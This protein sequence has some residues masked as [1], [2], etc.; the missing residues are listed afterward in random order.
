MSHGILCRATGSIDISSSHIQQLGNAWKSQTL[1]AIAS[2]VAASG[3]NA[4]VGNLQGN[5]MFYAND[6]MV[7][8]QRF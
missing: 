1:Q 3:H 5:R 4:N 8:L 7:W 2:N 6:Y